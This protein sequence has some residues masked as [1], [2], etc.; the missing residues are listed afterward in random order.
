MAHL[1]TGCSILCKAMKAKTAMSEHRRNVSTV[2]S[3]VP[4]SDPRKDNPVSQS[5]VPPIKAV[6]D[7]V[8]RWEGI[9]N[10]CEPFDAEMWN[11]VCKLALSEHPDSLLKAA[12]EW[13]GVGLHAGFRS[14]EWAQETQR[15]INQPFHLHDFGSGACRAFLVGDIKFMT[16]TR[17]A[18]P[19]NEATT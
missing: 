5:F 16:N 9:P 13:F 10:R 11:F 6:L 17:R 2:L 14:S 8:K 4:R 18:V 12:C 3:S 7:D 1:A 19:L 15:S